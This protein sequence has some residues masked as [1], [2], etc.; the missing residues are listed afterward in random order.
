MLPSDGS[1]LHGSCGR[2]IARPRNGGAPIASRRNWGTPPA[3]RWGYPPF[4]GCPSGSGE[5]HGAAGVCLAHEEPAC[6]DHAAIEDASGVGV[7]AEVAEYAG[8]VPLD[9]LLADR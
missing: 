5:G 7:Q 1:R 2:Q 9:E 6:R 4:V 8:H 3:T